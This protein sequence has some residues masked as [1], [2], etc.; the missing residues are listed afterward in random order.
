MKKIVVLLLLLAACVA[1]FAA[2]DVFVDKKNGVTLTKPMGWVIAPPPPPPAQGTPAGAKERIVQITKYPADHAG[3]NP[4]FVMA[5]QDVPFAA[6]GLSPDG[7]LRQL[8]PNLSKALPDLEF[9]M[10]PHAT[11]A[12]D[13]RNEPLAAGE[14]VLKHTAKDPAGQPFAARSRMMYIRRNDQL[15]SVQATA[16]AAGPDASVDDFRDIIKSL[17]ITR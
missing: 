8:V 7:M 11:Q 15:I 12:Y 4:M 16:P 5:I 1:V 3:P 13:T 14:M 10:Q 17:V 6:R 9:E 2:D